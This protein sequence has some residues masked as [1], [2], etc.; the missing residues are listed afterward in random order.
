MRLQTDPT[1]GERGP[2]STGMPLILRFLFSR[3]PIVLIPCY[4]D[5][6][7]PPPAG[8]TPASP[9]CLVSPKTPAPCLFKQNK[10][11]G[12]GE[13]T[14]LLCLVN[15]KGVSFSLFQKCSQKSRWRDPSSG[16]LRCHADPWS[17]MLI[18]EP[19]SGERPSLH[20]QRKYGRMGRLPPPLCSPSQLHP[21]VGRGGS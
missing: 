14:H 11:A 6:H 19:G 1:T 16:S 17:L 2:T 12:R 13:N 18:T 21:T 7:P 3:L 10:R 9:S 8:K 4:F 5:P 20:T 15:P